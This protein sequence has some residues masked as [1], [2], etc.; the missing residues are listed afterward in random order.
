M[1]RLYKVYESHEEEDIDYKLKTLPAKV[2][3]KKNDEKMSLNLNTVKMNWPNLK[4]FLT[5]YPKRL[6]PMLLG[7]LLK[8]I[9]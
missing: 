5:K 2:L 7:E 6:F 8:G 3:K 9:Y 4:I 1:K